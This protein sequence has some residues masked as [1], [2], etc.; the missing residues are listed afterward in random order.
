MNSPSPV[1]ASIYGWDLLQP[2]ITGRKSFNFRKASKRLV[3]FVLVISGVA[4][5]ILYI[6][7]NIWCLFFDGLQASRR[8]MGICMYS[9]RLLVQKIAS[10]V[11]LTPFLELITSSLN[12][13]DSTG[14]P[15][16]RQSDSASS[17][18]EDIA[19]NGNA[20]RTDQGGDD[21]MTSQTAD[22]EPGD[23]QRE[24]GD[25]ST[26]EIKNPNLHAKIRTRSE[27]QIDEQ[28]ENCPAEPTNDG[29]RDAQLEGGRKSTDLHAKVSL[30]SESR[31][32]GEE[33]ISRAGDVP[34]DVP[35]SSRG[36]LTTSFDH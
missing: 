17:E 11:I 10:R 23:A 22:E 28:R 1:L 9:Y 6:I 24:A 35:S 31:R 34:C 30:G 20:G 7:I 15:L 33:P 29:A 5:Y 26:Q 25:E 12:R 19:D 14:Q 3:G 32:E 2:L 4:G 27:S 36:D 16:L 8:L 13:Q 18:L 21:R